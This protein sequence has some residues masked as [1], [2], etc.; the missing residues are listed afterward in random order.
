MTNIDI[1]GLSALQIGSLIQAGLLDAEH[2][3]EM[4]LAAI[5]TADP[6]VFTG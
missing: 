4:V 1:R 6:A 2:A 5:E 3:A